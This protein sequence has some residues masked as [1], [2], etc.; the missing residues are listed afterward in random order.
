MKFKLLLKNSI[1]NFNALFEV[2]MVVWD[3]ETQQPICKLHLL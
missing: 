2:A 3:N 1:V